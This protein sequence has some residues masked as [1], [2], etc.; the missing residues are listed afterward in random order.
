MKESP[1]G[2][3]RKYYYLTKLGELEL[4]EFIDSWRKIK[5]N[6]DNVFGEK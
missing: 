6:I 5:R 2:P 1:F 4:K 3:M